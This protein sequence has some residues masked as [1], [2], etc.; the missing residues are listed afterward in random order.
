M[1]AF[2]PG[3]GATQPAQGAIRAAVLGAGRIAQQHLACLAGLAGVQVVA[4]CDLSRALAESAAERYRAASWFTDHRRMLSEAQPDVVHITTP[5]ATHFALARDCLEANTHVLVEKPVTAT[6]EQ[7]VALTAFAQARNLRLMED[8]NYLFN[9]PVS[10]LL[11]QIAQGTLGD[12]IHAEVELC[13]NVLDKNYHAMD[14]NV[15]SP[16]LDVE[17][18]IIADFLPHMASLAYAVCGP[19][20]ASRAVWRKRA[21]DSPLPYD[22][23]RALLRC[24]RAEATLVFSAH[25]QPDMFRV[26]VHGTRGRA[27]ADIFENRLLSALVRPGPK[28][29]VPFWNA[30]D[31]SRALRRSAWRLL[32]RKLAGGPGG[33]EGLWLLVRRFYGCLAQGEPAPIS[34]RDMLEVNRMIAELKKEENRV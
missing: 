9:E 1:S 12:V 34:V 13:L 4:V 32:W 3:A 20:R 11:G 7:L 23:F 28:P 33:Y 16:T 31:E 2:A 15:R 8:Y 26:T 21:P 30:L 14:P 17:G 6:F 25:S 24:E 18:G 22:E 27:T 5:A 10:A 29:L 19:A